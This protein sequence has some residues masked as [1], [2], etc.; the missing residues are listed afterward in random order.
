M[1]SLHFHG[2]TSDFIQFHYELICNIQ[3]SFLSLQKQLKEPIQNIEKFLT[4]SD[5]HIHVLHKYVIH[6]NKHISEELTLRIQ[7]TNTFHQWSKNFI[8][9]L[10]FI[11]SPDNNIPEKNLK[12]FK[13]I[14]LENFKESQSLLNEQAVK[15]SFDNA[16]IHLFRKHYIKKTLNSLAR[17]KKEFLHFDKNLLISCQEFERNMSKLYEFLNQQ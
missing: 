3:Y 11:L 17:M 4:N 12:A 7:I 13:R 14:F 9:I 6:S 8:E 1:N 16:N 10:H 5:N 2:I 15:F